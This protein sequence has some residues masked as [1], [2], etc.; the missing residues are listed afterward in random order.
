M[1]GEWPQLANDYKEG[2]C[3]QLTVV[4]QHYLS[5]IGRLSS[6]MANR[7]E[8]ANINTWHRERQ[9]G[10]NRRQVCWRLCFYG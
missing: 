1:N 4:F 7:A 8:V 5:F 2:G 3:A 9:A 10:P 6:L